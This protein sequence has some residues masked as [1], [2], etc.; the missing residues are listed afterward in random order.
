MFQPFPPRTITVT[1]TTETAVDLSWDPGL[2]A[3]RIDGFRVYWDT[4]SGA[5]TGGAYAFDS[6]SNAGQATIVGTAATISGLTAGIE[7]FFTVT[8]MSD[9][10]DPGVCVNNPATCSPSCTPSCSLNCTN[11]STYESLMYPLTVGGA[12]GPIPAEVTATPGNLCTPIAEVQNVT[13]DK[14]D[15]TCEVCWDMVADPCVDGYQILGADSA[16]SA[17]NF[18][19]LVPDTGLTTCWS[20]D[21]SKPFLL[22]VAKGSGGTGPWGHFGQ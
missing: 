18:S 17:D 8:S 11:P 13:A 20:L 16:E 19:I 14:G 10:C 7:Y 21:P 1:G 15:G 4:T 2:I 22:V 9:Y 5:D 12:A 3:D 6:I